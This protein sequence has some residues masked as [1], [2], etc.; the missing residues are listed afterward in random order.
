MVVQSD[1]EKDLWLAERMALAS[2]KVMVDLL[3][4]RL[5]AQ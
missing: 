2:D 3:D 1:I 4:P 5:V